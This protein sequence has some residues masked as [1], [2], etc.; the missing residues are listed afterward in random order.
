MAEI[1]IQTFRFTFTDEFNK[2]LFTFAKVHQHDE[3]KEFKESWKNW[4]EEEDIKPLINIELKQLREKGF[5]GDAMDKMFKSARYYFRKKS[6]VKKPAKERKEYSNFSKE[7]LKNMDEDIYRQI[8]I[9]K[10]EKTNISNISP[11]E[12]YNNYCVES[13]ENIKNEIKNIMLR[14]PEID[15][16]ELSNKF[17]KTYKNRFYVIKTKN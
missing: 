14:I 12:A 10:D 9:N 7:L 16:R 6:T 1:E 13:K 2:E 3:R 5:E 17:K 4:I 15:V 8:N 11:E